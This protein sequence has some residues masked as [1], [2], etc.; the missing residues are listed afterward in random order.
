M[1]PNVENF[2]ANILAVQTA[3]PFTAHVF[4]VSLGSINDGL[5]EAATLLRMI[6][7]YEVYGYDKEISDYYGG[8]AV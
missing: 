8:Y 6:A 2:E 4:P 3:K 1:Y 5:K 7:F